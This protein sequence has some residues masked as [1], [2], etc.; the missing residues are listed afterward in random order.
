MF[1]IYQYESCPYC[2]RVRKTIDSLGLKV[3]IDFEFVEAS[4]GTPGRKEVIRLGGLSQVPFLVDGE[5]Q[6]YESLDII[7]YL[8]KKFS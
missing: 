7:D 4:Y 5:I 3:G 1:R 6:M 2:Y 8:Q